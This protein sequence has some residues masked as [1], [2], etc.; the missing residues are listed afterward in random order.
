M[1]DAAFIAAGVDEGI[2]VEAGN[3]ELL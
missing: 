2:V 3:A 1:S